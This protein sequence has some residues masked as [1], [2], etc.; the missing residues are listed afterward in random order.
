M[1]AEA[2]ATRATSP[3]AA[4]R[5]IAYMALSCGFLAGSDAITKWLT[6]GYPVGQLICLRSIFIFLP[7]AAMVW[8]DGGWASVR[9]SS[10]R[11]QA[12]RG[13]LFICTTVTIVMSFKLLPLADAVALMFAGPLFA[14]ALA[15]PMLGERVGWKR[16]CAVG[17]GFTGVLVIVR[18]TGEGLALAALM[19]IVAA[20]FSAVRDIVTRRITATESS[21]AIMICSTGCVVAACL[22]TIPFGWVMPTPA[23]MALLVVAG[24]MVGLAHYLMI[25]S[26]RAAEI[27]IVSPFKYVGLIW[28]T[29]IGYAVWG[30]FPDE[31]TS[32]G[33]AIVIASGVYIL[34]RET[35]RR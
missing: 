22:F 25:A 1:R 26:Y 6:T 21:N 34:R 19:P 9:I 13:G 20:L 28:A 35:A 7:I 17:V 24:I 30:H 11:D 14:T 33:A 15:R 16:W 12:L 27:A 29:A 3:A 4:L 5:G 2:D 10:L 31:W 32:I 18:P 8:R 23:D